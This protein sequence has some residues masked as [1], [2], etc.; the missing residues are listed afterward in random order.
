MEPDSFQSC[1]AEGQEAMD[2]CGS[3]ENSF[4]Y[5]GKK[6]TVRAGKP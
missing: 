3:K 5:R 1:T 4:G 2:V 6:L